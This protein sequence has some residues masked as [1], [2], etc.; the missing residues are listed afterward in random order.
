MKDFG[1]LS[2]NATPC[3]CG[4]YMALFHVPLC[5]IG[6]LEQ[7]KC[8]HMATAIAMRNQLSFISNLEVSCVLPASLKLIS[9][10]VGYGKI[11]DT[12]WFLTRQFLFSLSLHVFSKS[13]YNKQAL[14]YLNKINNFLIITWIED[15][16]GLNYT[17][18][19]DRTELFRRLSD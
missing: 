5:K 3:T 10:Q 1:F 8:Q 19:K 4:H 12:S 11:S 14:Y 13:S 6:L 2:C 9:L 17:D 18:E 15:N 16:E 7:A